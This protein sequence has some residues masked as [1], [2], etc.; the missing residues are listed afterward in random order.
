MVG[1]CF[2]NLLYF[3]GFLAAVH[4]DVLMCS[5]Y[6]L[7][8]HSLRQIVYPWLIYVHCLYQQNYAEPAGPGCRASAQSQETDLLTRVS[9]STVR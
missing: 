8:Y 4:I 7:L 1:I 6:G 3:V 2:S 5:G 9:Q